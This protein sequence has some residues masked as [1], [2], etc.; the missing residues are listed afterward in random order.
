MS[1][2]TSGNSAESPSLLASHAKYAAGAAKVLIGRDTAD[3][4][5]GDDR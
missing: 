5:V 2:Q 1:S 3:L 4:V